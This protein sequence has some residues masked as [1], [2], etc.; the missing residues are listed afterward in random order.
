MKVNL[1]TIELTDDDLRYIGNGKKA[2]RDEARSWCL[3][4]IIDAINKKQGYRK[5]RK[6]KGKRVEVLYRSPDFYDD[7]FIVEFP[8]GEKR[9]IKGTQLK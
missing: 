2:K 3:R 5:F 7:H 1:G 6:F 8:S 4:H 9:T